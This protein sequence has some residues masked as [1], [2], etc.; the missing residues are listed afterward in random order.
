M[1]QADNN[2]IQIHE[3]EVEQHIKDGETVQQCITAG[4]QSEPAAIQ[5]LQSGLRRS[6]IAS[7]LCYSTSS[8]PMEQYRV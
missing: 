4:E 5:A 2:S 3:S 1:T 6:P 7:T 8:K